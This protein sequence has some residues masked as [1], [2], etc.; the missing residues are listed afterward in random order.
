MNH[1]VRDI[2]LTGVNEVRRVVVQTKPF[3][4]FS[5]GSFP[6]VSWGRRCEG[7]DRGGSGV[8]LVAMWGGR[9]GLFFRLTDDVLSIIIIFKT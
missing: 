9:G 5:L 6:I 2:L 7:G 3:H 4:H 8:R 1:T